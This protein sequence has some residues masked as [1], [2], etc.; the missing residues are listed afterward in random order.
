[1]T[2]IKHIIGDALLNIDF[3]DLLCI[4]MN[5]PCDPILFPLT[6]GINTS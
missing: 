4:Q 3:K 5:V 2:R 6:P 1:M